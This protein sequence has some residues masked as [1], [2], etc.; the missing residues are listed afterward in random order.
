V[1]TILKQVI[2]IALICTTVVIVVVMIVVVL[3]VGLAMLVKPVKMTP[4]RSLK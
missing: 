1:K 3:T 2:V 4:N